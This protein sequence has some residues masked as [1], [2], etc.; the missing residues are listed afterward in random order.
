MQDMP[1]MAS[2]TDDD[3]RGA[4]TPDEEGWRNIRASTLRRVSSAFPDL[5]FDSIKVVLDEH[6]DEPNEFQTG[7]MR[8]LEFDADYATR[9]SGP[10]SL[11][12]TPEVPRESRRASSSGSLSLRRASTLLGVQNVRLCVPF[13]P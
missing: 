4:P 10:A 11:L 1:D 13:T 9:N 6:E 3:E 2:D 7:L 5:D 12:A 8:A